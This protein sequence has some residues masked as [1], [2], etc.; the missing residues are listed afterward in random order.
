[1]ALERIGAIGEM[2]LD[3]EVVADVIVAIT[4]TQ[5]RTGAA[6][7]AFVLYRANGTELSRSRPLSGQSLALVVSIAA[8]IVSV[9]HPVFGVV[10][11]RDLPRFALFEHE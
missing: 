11:Y 8:P 3:I 7:P 2:T 9:T 5:S 6:V 10:S 1:M 4:I